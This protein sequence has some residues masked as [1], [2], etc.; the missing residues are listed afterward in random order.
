ME[1]SKIPGRKLSFQV[2]AV[3][4]GVIL[5]AGDVLDVGRVDSIEGEYTLRTKDEIYVV[6]PCNKE[7]CKQLEDEILSGAPSLK[8]LCMTRQDGFATLEA[9]IFDGRMENYGSVEIGVDETIVEYARKNLGHLVKA[10]SLCESLKYDFVYERDDGQAF[11]FI[12]TGPALERDLLA[13]DLKIPDEIKL[14]RH[15]PK[16]HPNGANSFKVLGDQATFVACETEVTPGRS[17]Y[18]MTKYNQ[19]KNRSVNDR[20]VRLTL[21]VLNFANWTAVG[22]VS[23]I[24]KS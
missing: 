19:R 22:E 8:R 12:I 11:F 18:L 9:A 14:E 21:G 23:R 4:E 3:D 10:E 6:S 1:F 16:A 13:E 17:I 20:A 7:S 5:R 15:A 24:V 2:R